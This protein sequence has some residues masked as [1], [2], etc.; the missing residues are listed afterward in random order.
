MA[1]HRSGRIR[2]AKTHH[3]ADRSSEVERRKVERRRLASGAHGF[4]EVRPEY[5]DRWHPIYDKELHTYRLSRREELDW[6]HFLREHG[7]QV[8]EKGRD[9]R[10]ARSDPRG[11]NIRPL[12][13]AQLRARER[14]HTEALGRSPESFRSVYT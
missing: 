14:F 9:G 11:R 13:R 2:K 7:W 10:I 12:T 4:L 5:S 8:G 3:R 1:R 6:R